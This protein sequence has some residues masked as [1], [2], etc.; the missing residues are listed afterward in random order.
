MNTI[1]AQLFSL[2]T[3]RGLAALLV[4]FYHTIPL[5]AAYKWHAPALALFSE[6]GQLGVDI[7]FVI[8]GFVMIISVT[9]KPQ[10]RETAIAFMRAR[11]ARVVPLYWVMTTAMVLALYFLPAAFNQNK[12][13]GIHAFLSYFF[14]PYANSFT[15]TP[16]P[17][18]YVGWTLTYE[19]FFYLC[20]SLFLLLPRRSQVLPALIISFSVLVGIGATDPGNLVAKTLTNGLMVEFV[21]GCGI[22]YFYAKGLALGKTTALVLIAVGTAAFLASIGKVVDLDYRCLYWG[23]PASAVVA[24]AAFLER[25]GGW[26]RMSIATAIGDSSYSLYLSHVFVLPVV[27]KLLSSVP[28]GRSLPGGLVCVLILVASIVSAHV[29]YLVLERPVTRIAKK[30][31]RIRSIGTTP[32]EIGGMRETA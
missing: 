26:P 16:R 12:L 6:W 5:L 27:A 15:G 1:K 17:V 28:V 3:L 30:A 24:G 13:D 29:I 4:A 8:S 11:V 2:Q 9:G 14:V 23:I 19:M 21:F 10:G 20:F 25:A 7:F 31:L 18:L 32:T 22:G